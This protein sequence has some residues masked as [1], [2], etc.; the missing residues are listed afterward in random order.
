MDLESSAKGLFH[1]SNKDLFWKNIWRYAI[2][3]DIWSAPGSPEIN[4]YVRRD[5]PPPVIPLDIE[6]PEGAGGMAQRG[7]FKRSFGSRGTGQ[8]MFIGPRGIAVGPEGVIYV[9][10]SENARI[11]KFSS[12]GQFLLSFGRP[13]DEPGQFNSGWGGPRGV[14]VGPDGSVYV[15]DT[16]H[17]KR[18]RVQKFSADGR[19]V[20]DWEGYDGFF[21]PRDLAVDS[22][23][24]VYVVDTG[25]KRIQK[26][27]S[28]GKFIKTWGKDGGLPGE[29]DEPVG[30]AIDQN[31]QVYIADTGNKRI[32]IFDENGKFLR[33]INLL[34]WESEDTVGIEPYIAVDREGRIYATD[35]VQGAVIQIAQ[36]GKKVTH[37]GIQGSGPANLDKPSGIAMAS[38]GDV[39]VADRT[40]C[41]ISIYSPK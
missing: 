30:I 27:D 16:W 35:S 9:A 26:F 6:L 7:Q 36:D 24:S 20:H 1:P 38:N 13:G 2:Y 10:D 37:W 29:F 18:G 31:N 22:K 5:F 8:G 4:L 32:Q 17:Q 28:N 41:R 3:R 23:G 34:S 40:L 33:M 12:D 25:K 11:Q 15:A 19:F 14:A 39:L 21:G